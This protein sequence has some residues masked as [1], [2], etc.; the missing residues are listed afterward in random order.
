MAENGTTE[1]ELTLL[2]QRAI[3][4]LL[5]TR[6]VPLA[7]K[8]AGVPVRTLYRWLAEDEVFKTTLRHYE[9]DI[10]NATARALMRL[11][12]RAVQVIEDMLNDEEVNDSLRARLA[13][14]V[15][16]MSLK[17]REAN[18]IEERLSAIERMLAGTESGT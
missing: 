3:A 10:L 2:Q 13:M 17:L 8:R 5:E 15:P 16:E 4:A 14:A 12:K 9:G 11:N 6:T 1:K 7:A 18:T